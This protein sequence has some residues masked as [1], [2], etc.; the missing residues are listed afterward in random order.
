[1]LTRRTELAVA[2]TF[3]R[4]MANALWNWI[5]V[6]NED[7]SLGVHNPTYAKALLQQRHRRTEVGTARQ[8]AARA[9]AA[10]T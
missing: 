2:G 7:K 10:V 4:R 3:P 5:Y 9:S 6:N 8:V 1:M